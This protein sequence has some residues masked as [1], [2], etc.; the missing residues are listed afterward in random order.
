MNM[1]DCKDG[2]VQEH[3][4]N[5]NFQ[6]YQVIPWYCW[7]NPTNEN[8]S[9]TLF[10]QTP[11]H[12]VLELLNY[13]C[14]CQKAF[15]SSLHYSAQVVLPRCS[16]I[17]GRPYIVSWVSLSRIRTGGVR[18]FFL[19]L[20]SFTYIGH[21]LEKYRLACETRLTTDKQTGF[22]SQQLLLSFSIPYTTNL[23]IKYITAYSSISLVW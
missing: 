5:S 18:E 9:C 17:P 14:P 16:H 1:K 21:Y 4:L 2:E 19:L 7:N 3:I 15:Q 11:P 8:D 13:K 20:L 6:K 10:S 12:P 23:D 22:N